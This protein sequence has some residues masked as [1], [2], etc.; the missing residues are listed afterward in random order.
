MLT[1][2]ALTKAFSGLKDLY[3]TKSA[4]GVAH[5]KRVAQF[6]N[7]LLDLLSA[8]TARTFFACTKKDEAD[9][10]D[11]IR[12]QGGQSDWHDR[13]SDPF[14]VPFHRY[15]VMFSGILIS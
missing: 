14:P 2:L 13:P 3:E 15:F 9:E 7:A 1:G 10:A 5:S 8:N 12:N 6:I 11:N 4:T